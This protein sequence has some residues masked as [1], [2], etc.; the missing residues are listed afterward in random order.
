M[1]LRLLFSRWWLH[2]I[3]PYKLSK[4]T[5]YCTELLQM[6]RWLWNGKVFFWVSYNHFVIRN[7]FQYNVTLG[8]NQHVLGVN[9]VSALISIYA[10]VIMDTIGMKKKLNVYLIVRLHVERIPNAHLLEFVLAIQ[11]IKKLKIR[12]IYVSLIATK[13]VIEVLA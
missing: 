4:W 11:D 5:V 9:M 12:W 8:V 10:S 2:P 13:F 7:A 6:Q 3:L 1:L